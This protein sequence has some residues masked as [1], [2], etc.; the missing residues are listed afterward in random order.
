MSLKAGPGLRRTIRDDHIPRCGCFRSAF[1]E[2]NPL[3][4]GLARVHYVDKGGST[5][6]DVITT[7]TPGLVQIDELWRWDA[8]VRTAVGTLGGHALR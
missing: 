5:N 8:V 4:H 6:N 1:V 3:S 7:F 2:V